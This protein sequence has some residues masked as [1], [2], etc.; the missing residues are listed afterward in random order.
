MRV[1][2]FIRLSLH[3]IVLPIASYLHRYQFRINGRQA[4]EHKP[5]HECLKWPLICFQLRILKICL[6]SC[7]LRIQQFAF[8]SSNVFVFC[9]MGYILSGV[10]EFSE[11]NFML[12][13][14]CLKC[15][16]FSFLKLCHIWS[17]RLS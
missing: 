13:R 4:I 5:V 10:M 12:A 7:F 2:T 3:N 9:I 15:V 6:I 14:C 17:A 16:A 11:S 1:N 8:P